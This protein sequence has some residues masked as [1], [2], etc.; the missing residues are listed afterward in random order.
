MR[1]RRIILC[2][3]PDDVAIL[4]EVLRRRFGCSE[5]SGNKVDHVTLRTDSGQLLELIRVRRAKSQ[6]AAMATSLI[7]SATL[8][9]P[10]ERLGVCFDPDEEIEAQW[11]AGIFDRITPERPRELVEG[12]YRVSRAPSEQCAV[13][14]LRALTSRARPAH[15]S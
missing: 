5:P 6:L 9:S 11:R 1:G 15:R 14:R 10:L 2:E 7:A 13:V 8:D 12:I 4:R 3:G